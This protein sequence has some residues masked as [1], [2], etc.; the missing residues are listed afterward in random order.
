MSINTAKIQ[1]LLKP[2]LAA[3]FGDYPSYPSEWS[4]IFDQY[5]SDKQQEI[6]VEM[7]YTSF[8]SLFA[9]G[10]PVPSQEM[11]Q[12]YQYSYVHQYA[13]L[14]MT[15]TRQAIKDNLYKNEFPMMA[16]A[17]K[18]S[19]AQLKETLGASV[20]NNG[21]NANYLGGDA[22]PLFSTVHPIDMGVVSNSLFPAADLNEA[23]LE[24]LVILIGS[25]F[26]DVA[27]LLTQAKPQ[28]VIVPP[29]LQFTISRIL[30]SQFRNDTPT[31]AIN[32]LYHGDYIPQ[33]YRVNHYLN[34]PSA[35]FV[36]TDAPNALK[37]YSREELETDVYT[38]FDTKNL[39]ASA[40]ER[41]SFGWSNFRGIAAS[42]GM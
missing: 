19:M 6:E 38:D 24:A 29:Q 16:K 26:R 3:V 31:N 17:L 34:N 15:I 20:L 10:A 22:Q 36:T 1:L 30:D 7:K 27:G 37:Y 9:Q 11:R 5:E 25:Q 40:I 42:A 33:G 18:R 12:N 32:A 41:Y 23:S 28:K 21:F 35:F 14:Q 39:K 8:A 13:G 4:E 2:G